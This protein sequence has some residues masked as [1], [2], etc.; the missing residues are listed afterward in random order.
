MKRLIPAV[1]GFFLFIFIQCAGKLRQELIDSKTFHFTFHSKA[2]GDSF[3]IYISLPDNYEKSD[4]SYHTIYYMDAN[5]KSGKAFRTALSNFRKEGKSLNAISIG[6]G[7]FRNYRELRRRDLITPFIKNEKDSLISDDKVFGHCDEFYQF[8]R[9]ELIPMIEAKYR[10]NGKRSW[11]GHSLGGLFA[12]YA[13]FKKDPVFVNHVSLSPALW[14]NYS[15]IYEFEKCYFE[16]KD[17][18]KAT[19]Y[20][21]A[22][23]KETMNKILNGARKMKTHLDSRAY[24]NLNFV[25]KEFEGESHNSEVPLALNWI[26]PEI[27]RVP[28]ESPPARTPN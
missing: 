11:V 3:D 20:L 17:K 19:L 7:H 13:L 18:Q 25:Y 28:A 12:F 23:S 1:P 9:D 16:N 10:C 22:G 27:V 15:N 26:L 6:I 4:S 8:L 14:I 5:L 24:P 21:C 2:V